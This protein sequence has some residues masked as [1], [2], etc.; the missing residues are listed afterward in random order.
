MRLGI[1]A[2]LA[3]ALAVGLAAGVSPFAS[4]SPDGLTKVAEDQGFAETG[5]LHPVQEEAPAAGYALP[6]VADD[7]AATAAA[8]AAGTLLVF[9]L[10]AGVAVAL[11]RRRPGPVPA[12]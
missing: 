3:V 8:G 1:V 5:R 11:R 12:A 6:G 9:A 4:S 2:A 7:R 10:G